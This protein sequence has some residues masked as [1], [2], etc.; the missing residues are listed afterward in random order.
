MAFLLVVVVNGEPI[1]AQFYFRDITQCD[2]FAYYGSPGK[3]QIN[4]NYQM[5]ENITA[6]CIPK[7]VPANTRTWD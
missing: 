2:T 1:P 4:R 3:T 6:Y 5:Q 7:R